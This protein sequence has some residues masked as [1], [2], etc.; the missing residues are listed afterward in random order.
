MGEAEIDE[1][2]GAAEVRIGAGGTILVHQLKGPT[3]LH[4]RA[5]AR[6]RQREQQAQADGG[7]CRGG[8]SGGSLRADS[9]PMLGFAHRA[10]PFA[11]HPSNHGKRVV[12]VIFGATILAPDE[13]ENAGSACDHGKAQICVRGNCRGQVGG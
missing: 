9:D 5:T 10:V 3:D 7:P 13:G 1:E 6:G 12:G 4:R 2:V 11:D 8:A